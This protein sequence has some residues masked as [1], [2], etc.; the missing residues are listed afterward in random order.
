VS[1]KEV[2]SSSTEAKT[3]EVKKKV[4]TGNK[5]DNI[6]ILNEGEI[7]VVGRIKLLP[8][9]SR[10]ER[11]SYEQQRDALKDKV[12]VYFSDQFI[13]ITRQRDERANYYQL[14]ELNEHFLFKVKAGD[15]LYYSG[16]TVPLKYTEINKPGQSEY[17]YLYLPGD[18]VYMLKPGAKAVY[19]GTLRYYRNKENRIDR[20][21]YLDEFKKAKKLLKE[22]TGNSDITLHRVRQVKEKGLW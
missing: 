3:E 16:S 12:F 20:V 7:Y 13:D 18:K 4:D 5:K 19:V 15:K 22:I 6:K 2:A 10:E 17:N 14:E 1:K 11:L 21:S 8:P 9:L